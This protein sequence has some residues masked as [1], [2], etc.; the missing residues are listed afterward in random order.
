[1]KFLKLNKTRI[2][3]LLLGIIILAVLFKS[4]GAEKFINDIKLLGWRFIIIVALFLFN[5]I[6]LTYA[7]KLLINHPVKWNKFCNLL[8]ARVAGDSTSSINAMGA[9]AGEPIKALF[10]Q[11]EIPLNTGLASVVLDRTTHTICNT[12]LILTGIIFSFFILNLPLGI[13]IAFLLLIIFVLFIMIIILK[14]QK[15]GFIEFLINKIP[16]KISSKFMDEARLKKVREIDEEIGIILSSKN[17]IK[18]FYK[19]LSMRYVSVLIT[20]TLEVYLIIKFINIDIT[21]VNSMFVYIFTLFLTSVVFFMPANIGTSE[22]SYSLALK[23]LGYD[24]ALG[25]TV[26]IIRRLR[27]FVWAGIGMLILFYGSLK[28]EKDIRHE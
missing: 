14:K 27:T 19:S 16:V 22:A 6:V 12:L 15:Q 1:M 28:K 24:P 7:W 2:I 26:G 4:F 8:C 10:M 25:L 9:V 3:F 5:N 13:S 23:F 17:N 21:L 11:N 20:G 18:K